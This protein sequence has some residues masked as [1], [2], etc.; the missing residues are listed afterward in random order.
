MGFQVT[1]QNA[2]YY[3]F[4]FPAQSLRYYNVKIIFGI[5]RIFTIL[6]FPRY[7]DF[8]VNLIGFQNNAQNAR[9]Y[10]FEF[11]GQSSRYYSV[12]VIFGTSRIFTILNFPSQFAAQ[13]AHHLYFEV[14][15]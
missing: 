4:E 7:F 3:D 9:Y 2:R 6:D 12:K 11:P 13:N 14:R 8:E 10:D 15:V 1:A 5:N